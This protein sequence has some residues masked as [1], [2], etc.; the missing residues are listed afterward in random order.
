MTQTCADEIPGAVPQQLLRRGVLKED[1]AIPID[2]ENQI[3][4]VLR[5]LPKSPETINW[6][7]H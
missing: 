6:V 1:K 7:T 5:Q 3:A 4:Y 2:E